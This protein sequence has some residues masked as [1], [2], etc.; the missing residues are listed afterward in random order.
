MFSGL[1]CES[2]QLKSFE[3]LWSFKK[4]NTMKIE[5]IFAFIFVLNFC[6]FFILILKISD[7]LNPECLVGAAY[8][9]YYFGN[10]K[11]SEIISRMKT[12][13]S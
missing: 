13:E 7:Y 12:L 5:K 11:S 10:L 3:N 8:Y 1:I 4:S 9:Y 2:Y 6:R